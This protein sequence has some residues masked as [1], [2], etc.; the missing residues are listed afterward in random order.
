VN[1]SMAYASQQPWIRNATLRDNVT[2][3]VEFDKDRYDT[4]LR[5]CEMNSDLQILPAGDM[6]EIGEKGI[7]LSG[8]Q[9]QRVSL[10]RAVYQHSD[11][12]LLDDP[13]SAVDAHVGQAI[14]NN[15]IRDYLDGTTRILVTHQ[16]QY[17]PY[18]DHIIVLKK[19][20]IVEMGTYEQLMSHGLDFSSLMTTHVNVASQSEREQAEK[21]RKE[22]KKT[23]KKPG[24][25]QPT[26]KAAS[27][28]TT[29]A[30]LMTDED[31][32]VG[33]VGLDVYKS[34]I[35]SMGYLTGILL[36]F[37]YMLDTA[38]RAL[39]DWWISKWATD[40]AN[41][42]DRPTYYILVYV[43]ISFISLIISLASSIAGVISGLAAAV[44]I[45]NTMFQRVLRSPIAFFDTTPIGR[46]LNRFT[47]DIN[48]IDDALPQ[49]ITMALRV[50][51]GVVAP[52]IIIASVTPF[53]L[54]LMLPWST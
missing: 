16:L 38:V 30:K 44:K 37:F 24:A 49:T 25:T 33:S 10:A 6:T 40:I 21:E 46:I 20:E 27:G 2:F 1:G 35:R 34:Y 41:G 42:I 12:Y 9:K 7:N 3:G 47:K 43:L 39:S 48:S 14:F 28:Q 45:H 52:L 23:E 4:A 15:C 17:L 11:I 5:V 29:G 26:E 32:L 8:G 18:V 54:V 19:G 13:L 51:F 53:F 22:K 50:S 36:V 31:R